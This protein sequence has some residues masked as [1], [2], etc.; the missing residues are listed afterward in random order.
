MLRHGD[1]RPGYP[2]NIVR[3]GLDATNKMPPETSR[4]WGRT[5]AMS[6]EVIATVDVMWDKLGLPGSGQNIWKGGA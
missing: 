2:G 5:I 3:M 1:E 6:D 4:D